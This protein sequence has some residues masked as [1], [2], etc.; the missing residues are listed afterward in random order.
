MREIKGVIIP[1]SAKFPKLRV[2]KLTS[3]HEILERNGQIYIRETY[4]LLL[5]NS[6]LY[7]IDNIKR[8]LKF[9]K[10]AAFKNLKNEWLNVMFNKEKPFKL[11]FCPVGGVHKMGGFQVDIV[12]HEMI[13]KLWRFMYEDWFG[14]K[15]RIPRQK[16]IEK[17]LEKNRMSSVIKWLG[18]PSKGRKRKI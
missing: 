6:A 17:I 3:D 2:S 11:F 4:P 16:T 8:D 13:N 10:I 5:K 14:V 18:M 12:E 7:S 1:D 15:P 9:S